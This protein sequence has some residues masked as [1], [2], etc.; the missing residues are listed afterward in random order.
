VSGRDL[1]RIKELATAGVLAIR[2]SKEHLRKP[3]EVARRIHVALVSRGY[4]GPEPAFG[5]EWRDM[6]G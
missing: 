4:D 5:A 2:M 6:F 1:L 3:R